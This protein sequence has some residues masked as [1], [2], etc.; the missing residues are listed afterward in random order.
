MLR[1]L[2]PLIALVCGCASSTTTIYRD[3]WQPLAARDSG[4]VSRL[5]IAAIV[6]RGEDLSSLQTA[7]AEIIGYHAVTKGWALRAGSTGGTHFVPVSE[8]SR[9]RTDCASWKGFTSCVSGESSSWTRVAVLRVEPE[10]WRLL[11]PHLIPPANDLVDA[12]S[13]AVVRNGCSVNRGR[14]EVHCSNDWKLV[15]LAAR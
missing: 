4:G 12:V 13:G 14:G 2:A 3:S 1:T 8:V 6:V 9:S 7:R 10:N 5:L 15:S 11:P